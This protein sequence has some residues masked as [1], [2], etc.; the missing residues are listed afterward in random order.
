MENF[1][2]TPIEDLMKSSIDK[3]DDLLSKMKRDFD[4]KEKEYKDKIESL[5]NDVYYLTEK[6]NN[7]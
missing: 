3:L 2:L 4:D 5:E 7:Q 1:D 6:L